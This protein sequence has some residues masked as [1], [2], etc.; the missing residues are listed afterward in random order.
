MVAV[1][2]HFMS[3]ATGDSTGLRYVRAMSPDPNAHWEPKTDVF[4]NAKGELVIKVELAG[5]RKEQL[6]LTYQ[7]Q[8][9]TVTG[10]RPDVDA[11]EAHY[12]TREM[13]WGGFQS[14]IELPWGFDLCRANAAYQNG[15]LRIVV[16]PQDLK[17]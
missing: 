12:L 11:G 6:E 17:R 1:R 14:V 7:G 13:G 5:L 4:V 8:C 16:P 15:I 3:A 2:Q 10:E 9:L